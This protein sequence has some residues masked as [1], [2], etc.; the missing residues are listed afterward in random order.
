MM[1]SI[2]EQDIEQIAKKISPVLQP[3]EGTT[4]LISG[5]AGFIG[6]YILRV[7]AHLNRRKFKKPCKVLSIDNYL[8]GVRKQNDDVFPSE[9]FVFIEKD[10]RYPIEIG[11]K[12]QYIIHAAGVASPIYYQK[13][14]LETIE[15]AI[16]GAKHLLELARKKKVKSFLY[17]S[18]SEI[19]G[20]PD[21]SAVPTPETYK[22]N[23]SS[24]GDRACY[25]ESKRLGET[26]C[27]TYHALYK[28]PVKIV[29][30]FNIYGPGM[31][32]NDYRVIPTFLYRA[33]SNKYLPV[34]DKGNQT[35]T[36]CYISDAVAGFFQVLLTTKNGEIYNVGNDRNEINMMSLADT[37]ASLFKKKPA[38]KMIE[39]P[40]HYPSDEPKRRCPDL[41]KIK[42]ELGYE[43]NIDLVAG[44][45]RTMKWYKAT[46]EI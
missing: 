35:R 46:Y 38:V 26:L 10:I 30:P 1:K 12:I 39:Y 9:Q 13:Y 21:P 8:T 31:K 3:L 32:P 11:E 29:R 22:G 20:D 27:M 17:F 41:S 42:R 16:W 25:D 4:L 28:T 34:H 40:N 2:I 43:A 24:V 18:S 19:Y 5:G 14:P 23:V 45:R 15:T 37:I 36:F 6:T 7:I 44:L 33:L